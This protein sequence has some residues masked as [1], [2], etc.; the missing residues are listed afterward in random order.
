MTAYPP[1]PHPTSAIVV[2]RV[3]R[4][5]AALPPPDQYDAI[6]RALRWASAADLATYADDPGQSWARVYAGLLGALDALD[7]LVEGVARGL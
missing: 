1:L 6:C 7:A 5:V 2:R 4:A 3:L